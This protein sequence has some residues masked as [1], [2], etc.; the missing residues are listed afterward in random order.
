[1][2][3]SGK[4]FHPTNCLTKKSAMNFAKNFVQNVTVIFV[5]LG[6]DKVHRKHKKSRHKMEVCPK[7]NQ[8]K[9]LTKHHVLPQRHFGR[10]KFILKLCRECH[11]EIEMLIPIERVPDFYYFKIVEYFLG[12]GAVKKFV[13]EIK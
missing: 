4:S 10:S 12:E 7:C 5:C 2:N 3:G 13:K 1:V 6:K 9:L 11:D 8:Y